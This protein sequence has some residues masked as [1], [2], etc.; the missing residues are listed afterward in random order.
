[1]NITETLL[2]LFGVVEEEGGL[3]E[4]TPPIIDTH[5]GLVIQ[6]SASHRKAEIAGWWYNRTLSG[7]DLNRTFHKSWKKVIESSRLELAVEQ[8]RHYLS[9]Y[10]TNFEGETYIPDEVLDVP[11]AS[12]AFMVVKGI[13]QEEIISRC[14]DL[15]GSGVA[16]KE[17]TIDS[18]L[19]ILSH[20]G[21]TFKDLRQVKNKEARVRLIDE[22]GLAPESAEEALR[23]VVYKA[24]GSSVVIKNREACEAIRVSR[25]NPEAVFKATGLE[26]MSTIFN[27]Y[28]PIFLSFKNKCQKTINKIS[29]L[30]KIHHQPLVENPL[31]TATSKKINPRKEQH[32]LENATVFA[33]FKA[34]NACYTRMN[35]QTNFIYQVRNGK[36]FS[37]ELQPARYTVCEYNFKVVLDH[38]KE[39]LRGEDKKVYIPDNVL[40]S[41]PTSEKQ[42]VGDVPT[43]TRF[44]LKQSCVGVYWKNSYGAQDIDLSGTSLHGGRIGWNAAY[45]HKG[46]VTYS[47]DITD[48]PDGAVEYLRSHGSLDGPVLVGTNIYS[49]AED[50]RYDI[51]VGEG[52]KAS[53]DYMMDPN[54]VEALIPT[55]S[56]QRQNYLGVIANTTQDVSPY[57]EEFILMNIGSG[58]LRVRGEGGDVARRAVVERYQK[59]IS[60][61]TLLSAVGYTLVRDQE[62]A[63]INLSIDK[64]EK[65]SLLKLFDV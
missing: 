36:S 13:P 61:N 44:L 24:T 25:Y 43:G 31:N 41:L 8:L 1:M 7:E 63:D 45:N 56:I 3:Y 59:A 19:N 58:S 51:V 50:C 65:D 34:L 23:F 18:I 29:S 27:R 14:L 9:T 17:D 10:G 64:L 62:E 40:Y 4:P 11:G 21:H 35:G 22:Q 32:W 6:F 57:K 15:L 30:S 28:K 12:L 52:S 16:L 53:L 42:F 20:Y 38:L 47:G 26:E 55:N 49:G 46:S 37:K 54:K 39:R 2:D 48:A 33:L 60:L 5:R